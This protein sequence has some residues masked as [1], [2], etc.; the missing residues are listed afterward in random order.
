LICGGLK[1]TRILAGETI[2]AA[3]C[4]AGRATFI[5]RCTFIVQRIL[6]IALRAGQR[7]DSLMQK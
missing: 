1:V 2:G 4:L 5:A 6:K 7:A 3:A